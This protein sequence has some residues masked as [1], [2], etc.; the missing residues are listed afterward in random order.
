MKTEMMTGV[1]GYSLKGGDFSNAG[2]ISTSIKRLLKENDYPG[3]LIQRVAIVTYESEI[4]VASYAQVG[5]FFIYFNEQHIKIVIK[6]RGSGIQNVRMAMQEGFSTA[7]DEVRRLGFGAGMGLPNI[8]KYAHKLTIYSKPG[9]GTRLFIYIDLEKSSKGADTMAITMQ[10][11]LEKS[12]FTL[13]NES[14]DLSQ[15]VSGG[16]AGDMLSDVNANGR[17]NNIWITML[18]HPNAISVASLKDFAGIVITGGIQPADDFIRRADEEGIPV[19][20]TELSSYE[21]VIILSS[22]GVEGNH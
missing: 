16:Y 17:K 19:L 5:Y 7:S 6:D 14:S 20:F 22:M 18:T 15:E 8:K 3:R 13:L 2:R 10:N 11:V 9:T 1:Y 12:N 21:A 4:N